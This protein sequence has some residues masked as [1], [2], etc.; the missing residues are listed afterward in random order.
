MRRTM[1][2]VFLLRH[3][4]FGPRSLTRGHEQFSPSTCQEVNP[5]R[6]MAE[7]SMLGINP[8]L[9]P[10][11]SAAM[12]LA[13]ATTHQPTPAAPVEEP[14]PSAPAPYSPTA[15]VPALPPPAE[16]A[17]PEEPAEPA[18]PADP[19]EPSTTAPAPQPIDADPL[20]GS[21]NLDPNGLV[22]AEDHAYEVY[23]DGLRAWNNDDPEA[24][25]ASWEHA[26]RL[27]PDGGAYAQSRL[28]L[29]MRLV[30][31]YERRFRH[32]GN[33]DDLRRQI[34]LLKGYQE[35]LP[36]LSSLDDA[37]A[38]QY[39]VHA[40][41]RIEEI[42]RELARFE[43][44][45]GSR[46]EQLAKSLRGEF[47]PWQEMSWQPTPEQLG[48]HR[49]SDDP[50]NSGAQAQENEAAPPRDE[51][52]PEQKH[53]VRPG[54]VLIALGAA[55]GLLGLGGLGV[56]VAGLVRAREANDFELLQSPSQRRE[57]IARGHQGNAMAIAGPAAGGALAVAGVVMLAVGS[58]RRKRSQTT[59][60]LTPSGGLRSWTLSV[61]NRF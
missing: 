52:E 48:W 58:A 55:S 54:T 32:R 5:T 16:A 37:T 18:E 27:L 47:D 61:T 59:V 44:E 50:R 1:G 4:G 49:R 38:R 51:L 53:G 24:A 17:E 23:L 14:R 6:L 35:R 60:A 28:A 21:T 9:C 15:P 56:G 57:Q 26:V 34:S 31:A 7:R 30:L 39:W 13:S 22:E 42:E 11:V 12:T 25:L 43:Q 41:Q 40:Q 46:E 19:A 20:T 33:L 8:L 10:V 2:E 45:P 3:E 36:Q 29:A